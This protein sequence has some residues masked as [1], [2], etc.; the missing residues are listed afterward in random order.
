VYLYIQNNY[1]QHT[2]ILCKHRLLFLMQ[3]IAIN[4]CT[5]LMYISQKSFNSAFSLLWDQ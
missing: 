5:A 1:I 4:F 3:L 2:Q